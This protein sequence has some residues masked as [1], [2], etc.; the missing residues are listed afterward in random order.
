MKTENIN[1]LTIN[2]TLTNVQVY[3]QSA[4]LS[5]EK[6]FKELIFSYFKSSRK[7]K[8]LIFLIYG[9]LLAEDF[10]G[11]FGHSD[12]LLVFLNWRESFPIS[13][14]DFFYFKRAELYNKAAH[15]DFETADSLHELNIRPSAQVLLSFGL[16]KPV[17]PIL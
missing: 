17:P 13:I 16:R 3:T 7:F 4:S 11:F 14:N 12:I 6:Y 10:F 2:F 1:T 9:L 5:K 8:S 15:T